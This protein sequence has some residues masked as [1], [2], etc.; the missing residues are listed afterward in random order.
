MQDILTDFVL[1]PK[2]C[3]LLYFIP[4]E[5]TFFVE[6]A[7]LITDTLT[8]KLPIESAPHTLLTFASDDG[9]EQEEQLEVVAYLDGSVLEV[10]VNG[11]TA[12]TT[13]VY[14][15]EPGCKSLSFWAESQAGREVSQSVA[16]LTKCSVWD[17]LFTV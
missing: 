16:V 3:S 13:R 10:F 4:A 5:E 1:D 9:K 15:N 6:R 2:A 11:R 12:I 8:K 17:G 7:D 14:L